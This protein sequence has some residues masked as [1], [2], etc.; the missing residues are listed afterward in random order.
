M[1]PFDE[2]VI[3]S[4]EH[5]MFLDFWP[6]VAYAYRTLFPGVQ[7]TLAFLSI[8]EESDPFVAQLRTHGNVEL[9]R[10]VDW[11]PEANQTK[12]VRFWLA[13]QRP[14]GHV[15]AI[16]DMD[17]IPIDR[18]WHLKKWEQRKPHSMLLVGQEVYR[19]GGEVAGQA[20]VSQMTAEA[21]LWRTLLYPPDCTIVPD[22]FAGWIAWLGTLELTGH[23]DVW[24]RV[25]AE[26]IDCATCAER[27][28]QK[29]F[30]DE[31]LIVELRRRHPIPVTSIERGYKVERDTIDR[32]YVPL[33][34]PA[35]LAAGEY[36]IAH[37]PRP[38]AHYSL[39]HELVLDFI[40]KRYQGGSRPAHLVR[41]PDGDEQAKAAIGERA[42]YALLEHAPLGSSILFPDPIS[43]EL[44]Y[45][46]RYWQV[47]VLENNPE[48][49]NRY[50]AHY[51]VGGPSDL[52]H[53]PA[54]H[55][56]QKTRMRL[57]GGE[58]EVLEK[59]F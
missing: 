55:A 56:Q 8:R 27:L 46:T 41:D 12:M 25:Q 3:A 18:D 9:I 42:W 52:V 2:I 16:E 54:F 24:S 53:H 29:L 51:C 22:N 57:V 49:F 37:G 45:L 33:F 32:S 28:G 6:H 34:N 13:A 1:K 39:I 35:R 43:D 58:L 47:S 19:G 4:N 21:E 23:L 20:P 17:V 38:W 15:V 7:V 50:P 30:S 48:R 26:G 40:A 11:C 31:A 44:A 5:W 14:A 36:I 59:I 10:P